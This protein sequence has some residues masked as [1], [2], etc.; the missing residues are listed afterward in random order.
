MKILDLGCGGNKYKSPNPEDVVIG[1]DKIKYDGVDVVHDLD[2]FPYPFE[3]NQF[4]VVIVK[5]VIEHLKDT[6]KVMEEIHR[7]L[8]LDGII[9]MEYP[10]YPNPNAFKDPTHLHVFTYDSFYFF[11]PMTDF[12]KENMQCTKARFEIV[13]KLDDA[14]NTYIE[15]R[16]IK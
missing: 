13:N 2:V 5:H 4:D 7:I 15:L 3:N 9:K 14:Y 1:L 6:V 11:C 12:G 10:V 16:A 8:R